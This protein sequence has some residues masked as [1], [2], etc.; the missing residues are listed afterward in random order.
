M[1]VYDIYNAMLENDSNH[2]R[3]HIL[4]S[5]AEGKLKGDEEHTAFELCALIDAMSGFKCWDVPIDYWVPDDWDAINEEYTFA[6]DLCKYMRYDSLDI[7]TEYVTRKLC[8]LIDTHA[9]REEIDEWYD[10]YR[11][12]ASDYSRVSN[13]PMSDTEIKIFVWYLTQNVSPETF[14]ESLSSQDIHT[15]LEF[16]ADELPNHDMPLDDTDSEWSKYQIVSQYIRTILCY[17]LDQQ[18]SWED[19]DKWYRLNI[20]FNYAA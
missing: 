17:W 7:C 16:A 11:L 13:Y 1:T 15:L 4:L 2:E 6:E 10:L 8:C 14:A 19:I 12:W 20:V 3:Y 5:S 9:P 18:Y